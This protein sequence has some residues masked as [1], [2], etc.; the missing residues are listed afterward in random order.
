MPPFLRTIAKARR[1]SPLL[2][3]IMNPITERSVYDSLAHILRINKSSPMPQAFIMHV[4]Q[5]EEDFVFTEFFQIHEH[6]NNKVFDEEE[7][8]EM[9]TSKIEKYFRG[10]LV[11]YDINT[12]D[13]PVDNDSERD[14]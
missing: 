9:Y 10:S 5:E 14:L 3:G 2:I 12:G 1:K 7:A 13:P 4:P 11:P 6:N 8:V